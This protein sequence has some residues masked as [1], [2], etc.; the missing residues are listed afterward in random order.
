MV[1]ALSV[2]PD[3]VWEAA[4]E[5]RALVLEMDGVAQ[6]L[7]RAMQLAATGAGQHALA[8]AA[9]VAGLRWECSVRE[10][11]AAGQALARVTDVAAEGYRLVETLAR[12]GTT[13]TRTPAR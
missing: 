1:S 9:R 3:R 12:Q 8:E 6:D 4:Q 7:A 11:G 10:T 2:N 5:L 13:P